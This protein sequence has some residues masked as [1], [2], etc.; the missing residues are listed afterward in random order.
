MRAISLALPLAAWLF[1]SALAANNL[2]EQNPFIEQ[3]HSTYFYSCAFNGQNLFEGNSV[4]LPCSNCSCVNGKMSCLKNLFCKGVC[5]VTGSL[6]GRTFDDTTFQVFGPCQY[7]LV[8]TEQFTIFLNSMPC[9]TNEKAVCIQSVVFTVPGS[10]T[11]TIWNNGSVTSSA[12]EVTMPYLMENYLTVKKVTSDFLELTS[13]FGVIIQYDPEGNRVYTILD[14]SYGGNTKGLCGNYDHNKNNELMTPSGMLET[15]SYYFVQSWKVSSACTDIVKNEITVADPAWITA[16]QECQKLKSSVFKDC[17]SVVD[18]Y[19]YVENCKLSIYNKGNDEKTLCSI[20]IDYADQCLRN[21]INTQVYEAFPE[22]ASQCTDPNAVFVSDGSLAQSD[23]RSLSDNLV[24]EYATEFFPP[25]CICSENYYYDSLTNSC[26]TADNCPCYVGTKTFNPGE[27]I[28]EGCICKAAASCISQSMS[29]DIAMYG[30]CPENEIFISCMDDKKGKNCEA[31]CGNL[32]MVGQ[33]CGGTCEPGCVCTFG[34]VRN[35]VGSCVP[36]SECPC[37]FKDDLYFP[38]E[39]ILVDC[40]TCTCSNGK[41]TCTDNV[42]SAIC[43]AYAESQF[44]TFD[45]FWEKFPP[46]QCEIILTQGQYN[47]NTNFEVT[48]QS[49]GCTEYGN[50][51]CRKQVKVNFGQTEVVILGSEVTVVNKDNKFLPNIYDAGF[52]TVVEF[53]QGITVYYDAHLDVIIQIRPNLRGGLSG[54]CG[55]ADGSTVQ[56]AAYG[57]MISYGLSNTIG[58]CILSSVSP[59]NVSEKLMKYIESRCSILKS[60]VFASCHSE[61]PVKNYYLSCVEETVECHD[62]DACLCFCS[63]VAAYARACCRKGIAIDWRTPDMCPAPCEYFNR[64]LGKGPFI[65]QNPNNNVIVASINTG[66]V[67]MVPYDPNSIISQSF[68]I[69]EGLY[70]DPYSPKRLVSLE[71]VQHPNYFIVYNDDGTVALKKWQSASSFRLH[72]TFVFRQDRWIKVMT[73]MSHMFLE[74]TTS[75]VDQTV[76]LKSASLCLG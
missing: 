43:N 18:P 11:L 27:E 67:S 19:Q 39:S 38:G 40:N 71:S 24:I 42:C 37:S 62:G 8:K 75:V 36:I 33:V 6:I 66:V 14:S 76:L 12:G 52:Y 32:E 49:S 53:I 23:C 35:N 34:Y 73:P 74:A 41:F 22:C 13:T 15:H 28:T 54:M 63:S 72:S 17:E 9:L 51:V 60:D 58:E 30:E 29:A 3:Q 69:T 59:S 46:V 57:N 68:M 45:M 50:A 65:L 4:N 10:I 25:G 5:S 2:E 21:E 7:I 47:Q 1:S 26:V 70:K 64:E 20:L 61:V 44:L 48:V 16:E 56:E 31:S 55:D